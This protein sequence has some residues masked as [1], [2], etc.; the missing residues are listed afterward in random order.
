MI[1]K[2]MLVICL[3]LGL[4][5]GPADSETCLQGKI[6]TAVFSDCFYV[7][8][9]NRSSGIAVVLTGSPPLEGEIVSIYGVCQTWPNGERFFLSTEMYVLGRQDMD[10]M[11]LSVPNSSVG[12]GSAGPYTTGVAG[13]TGLNNV[14]LLVRVWG[15]V[16]GHGDSCFWINDGSLV[17]D[18]KVDSGVF[19]KPQI[20]AFVIVTG[21]SSMEANLQ[22]P[23]RLIRV[24]HG[25]DV[26]TQ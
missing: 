20:G 26:V 19:P 3:G 5:T 2:M 4:V 24:R 13:G 25:E 1:G 9:P 14:G 12:G 11:S 7:E 17:G 8:E 10:Y 22:G 21:I 18:L 16:K 15:Q 6:V 23:S